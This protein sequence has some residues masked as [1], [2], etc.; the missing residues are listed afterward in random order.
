VAV[1]KGTRVVILPGFSVFGERAFDNLQRKFL[2]ETPQKE[3]VN[4]HA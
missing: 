2:A 3:F 1:E 4:S